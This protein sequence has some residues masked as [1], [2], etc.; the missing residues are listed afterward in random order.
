VVSFL[1]QAKQA[2]QPTRIKE[3]KDICIFKHRA[4]TLVQKIMLVFFIHLRRL[5]RGVVPG[6]LLQ[7]GIRAGNLQWQCTVKSITSNNRV[8]VRQSET[9]ADQRNPTFAGPSHEKSDLDFDRFSL[10]PFG[11][12][13]YL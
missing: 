5:T 12:L 2:L 1:V 6:F 13:G 8:A 4:D 7:E 11:N 3:S 9:I 10:A